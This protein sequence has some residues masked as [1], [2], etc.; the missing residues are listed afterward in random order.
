MAAHGLNERG[1]KLLFGL[2]TGRPLV[3]SSKTA[4]VKWGDDHLISTDARHNE[5]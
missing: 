3:T 5:W 4:L 1:N 2:A